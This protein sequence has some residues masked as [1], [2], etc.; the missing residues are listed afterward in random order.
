MSPPDTKAISEPSGAIEGSANAGRGVT[1]PSP[2]RLVSVTANRPVFESVNAV[3]NV[4]RSPRGTNY[5][6]P[7]SV[8]PPGA[9]TPGP[10][11]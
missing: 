6:L 9:A 3:S 11:A 7:P 1:A 2:S 8:S 10:G 5:G 4:R